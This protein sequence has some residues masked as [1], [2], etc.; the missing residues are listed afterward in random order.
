MQGRA[1]LE[2]DRGRRLETS[3]AQDRKGF[4]AVLTLRM[5][6]PGCGR[7][8]ACSVVD[9]WEQ[10]KTRLHDSEPRHLQT[11]SPIDQTSGVQKKN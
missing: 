6:T 4:R 10:V 1:V 3:W 5:E 7:T 9:S 11:G 2:M 8:V